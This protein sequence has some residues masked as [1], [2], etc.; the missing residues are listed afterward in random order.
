MVEQGHSP[1]VSLKSLLILAGGAAF[2]LLLS[3]FVFLQSA[4]ESEVKQKDTP[5]EQDTPEEASDTQAE[6]E[7]STRL[8]REAR[9]EEG[10]TQEE[11][12]RR[13]RTLTSL[14][15]YIKKCHSLGFS[16][17]RIREKI[18][19]YGHNEQIIDEAFETEK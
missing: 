8:E 2:G 13:T 12:E 18:A 7:L 19:E 11:D 15:K 9:E 14:R 6:N 10:D 3:V 17:K 5:L 16:S 1:G 4:A